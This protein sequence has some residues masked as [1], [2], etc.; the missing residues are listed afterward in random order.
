MN[1][2]EIIDDFKK[3]YTKIIE[4]FSIVD[5]ND[6]IS[7]SKLEY[8][9]NA[10]NA[11]TNTLRDSF[12]KV[13]KDKNDYKKKNGSFLHKYQQK[14]K[15]LN[16]SYNKNIKNITKD[17]VEAIEKLKTKLETAKKDSEY[18]IEQF[19]VEY[20]YFISTSDQNKF[21]LSNDFEEAKKRFDY[22]KD[23]LRD[24]YLDIVRKSNIASSEIKSNL[25]NQY[26][27]DKANLINEQKLELEK[28]EKQINA[29]EQELANITAALE[30][31]KSGMKEKYRQE[32]ASL[33]ENIKKIADEKNRI[34]DRARGE[35]TKSINDANIEKENKKTIYQSQSQTLLKEFVTKINE[36]DENAN[37]T[38]KEFESKILEIKRDYYATVYSKTTKFHNQLEQIY[39]ASPSIDKITNQLIKYKNKMHQFD[40]ATLRKEKE[41]IVLNLTKENTIKAL[42]DRNNKNFLE[43]DKNYSIK[44]INNQEQFDNKYY[45]ENENFYANEFNYTVKTANYKFSQKANLLRCQSQIRTKLL[46]RNF[47]GISANYYKKIETIQN[48][49][50]TYKINMTTA[51]KANQLILTYLDDVYNSHLYLEETTNLLEIEKN[52]LLKEFNLL[53]YQYNI[54]GISLLK[55]YGYKKI[56][57]ENQRAFEE[58]KIKIILENLMLDKNN[59]STSYSIKREQLNEIFSKIKT[60]IINNHDLKITKEGYFTNLLNN[61]V[62]YLENLISFYLQFLDSYK[63]NY[64]NVLHIILSD[65]YPTEENYRYLESF[66]N[67]LLEIFIS[68]LRNITDD[69]FKIIDTSITEKMTYIYDFKYKSSLDLLT[70]D[71]DSTINKMK[72]KEVDFLDKIDSSNKT[73]ENFRQKIYTLYND[74]EMLLLNKNKKKLDSSIS[75]TIKQ[76]ELKIKDYRE[77]IDDYTKIIRLCNDDLQ[78]LKA[79]FVKENNI[80]KSESQKINKMYNREI[81]IFIRLKQQFE[82][83]FKATE[84]NL[85]EFMSKNTM[86]SKSAK[87]LIFIVDS[88]NKKINKIIANLKINLKSV[89]DCFTKASQNDINKRQL[90]CNLE[91]N[92]EVR[93]FNQRY[94][95]SIQEYK[96]EYEQIMQEHDIKINDETK[97]LNQMLALYSDK[98]NNAFSD[99]KIKNNINENRLNNYRN[100]FYSS[101]YALDENHQK[102][103]LYHKQLN[104]NK[105]YKY[106]KDKD[107]LNKYKIKELNELNLKLKSFLKTKNEEIEHLPIAYKFNTKM[108]N[109]EAK[110]KN[111][112]LHEDIKAAKNEYNNQNNHI[113]KNIKLLKIG[114]N[115]DNYNNDLEQKKNIIEERKNYIANLRQ[116]LKKIKINL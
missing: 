38:K 16:D 51:K 89:L 11:W 59:S 56:D 64:L 91:F 30:N 70:E 99:F 4:D 9:E 80:Y 55:D 50:N 20:D 100:S 39:M 90:Q 67:K 3:N 114:L 37:I 18:K 109:N 86:S 47:D 13:T 76:T 58:K 111:N 81:M 15:I 61:D 19:E 103:A 26:I 31:E 33:N 53:Q 17:Y 42:S 116:S 41:L 96:D 57:I 22:Q 23:E 95:K 52:K 107:T 108:L 87:K 88:S 71:Y 112:I 68:F 77:K 14:I 24:S 6:P 92:N 85:I 44:R 113:E 82:N 69:F 10:L 25:K 84:D 110:K 72:E 104:I 12:L 115:Q 27:L 21:I 8:L 34:I 73:I 101:Y 83:I 78:D 29:L 7:A 105:D 28:I 62:D 43:I 65:I 46:E 75:Q 32:S 40:V 74:K 1:N 98:L 35:Y 94:N 93:N 66:L 36:I 45:Q 48:K 102:N 54:D 106:K 5:D 63:R 79:S 97:L 60:Q 2:L 49:I